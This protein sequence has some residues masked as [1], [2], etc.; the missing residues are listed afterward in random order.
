MPYPCLL[1][2]RQSDYHNPH[3]QPLLPS[4]MASPGP[5]GL[6]TLLCL[7][8]AQGFQSPIPFPTMY[9]LH[10]FP[11][12]PPRFGGP[13]M[14]QFGSLMLLWQGQQMYQTPSGLSGQQLDQVKTIVEE[15]VSHDQCTKYGSHPPTTNDRLS[16]LPNSGGDMQWEG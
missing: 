12:I 9:G 15:V 4:P 11:M 14:T 13:M 2:T 3:R 10:G 7:Q 8:L 1:D 16:L 6:S 5:S